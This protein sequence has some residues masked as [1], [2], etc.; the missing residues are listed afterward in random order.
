[1]KK[2]YSEKDLLGVGKV[3]TYIL[4][5]SKS[6][7]LR[8]INYYKQTCDLPELKATVIE[9]FTKN[10]KTFVA[11]VKGLKDYHFQTWGPICKLILTGAL[12]DDGYVERMKEKFLSIRD[13]ISKVEPPKIKEKKKEFDPYYVLDEY[14]DDILREGKAEFSMKGLNFAHLSEVKKAAENK[15]ETIKSEEEEHESTTFAKLKDLYVSIIN[16]KQEKKE[17]IKK[18]VTK[19][20]DPVKSTKTVKY[21]KKDQNTGLKSINPSKVIGRNILLAFD[22]KTRE[23]RVYKS[24]EGFAFKGTT[25]RNI[26]EALSFSKTI[27]KPTEFFEEM[28]GKTIATMVKEIQKMKTKAKAVTPRFNDNMV[29]VKI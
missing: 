9:Y 11:T 22:A 8:G 27:R 24:E 2:R 1:M 25:L 28:K 20:V 17:I 4:S 10:D 13:H 14:E 5:P 12:D 18:V 19:K 6:E 23:A 26:N 29:I 15:L 16:F 7:I 21:L 3:P